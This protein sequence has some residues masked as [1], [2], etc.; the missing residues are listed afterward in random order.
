[1]K[2]IIEQH[3]LDREILAESLK[4]IPRLPPR[5]ALVIILWCGLHGGDAWTFEKLARRFHVTP[6]RIGT[7]KD[8]GL[9]RLRAHLH[10]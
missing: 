1:M 10:I 6:A 8:R 3:Y 4:A 9:E 2:R 7:L 5:E